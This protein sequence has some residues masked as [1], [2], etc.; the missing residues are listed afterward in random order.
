MPTN[1]TR[2]KWA[3]Y[4]LEA[5]TPHICF[6]RHAA[7]L[8]PDDLRDAIADLIADL[9]HYVDRRFRKR[10]PFPDLVARGVG[11]W[12][13]ERRCRDGDPPANDTATITINESN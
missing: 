11:M 1:A 4:A 10:V 6:G 9:G 8:H 5:F 12:S 3:G 2:A 13:A 7:D